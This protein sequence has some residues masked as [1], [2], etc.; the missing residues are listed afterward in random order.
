L[1]GTR[2]SGRATGRPRQRILS[3]VAA[4]LANAGDKAAGRPPVTRR[5]AGQPW[6][7]CGPGSD[8]GPSGR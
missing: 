7:D 5:A 6:R 1:L 8:D 2:L 4:M 3:L